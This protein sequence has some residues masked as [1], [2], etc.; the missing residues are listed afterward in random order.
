ML[1]AQYG[2]DNQVLIAAHLFFSLTADIIAGKFPRT[3][4]Y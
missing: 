4:R 1:R 3:V 2:M